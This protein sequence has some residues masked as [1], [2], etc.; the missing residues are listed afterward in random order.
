M[1]EEPKPRESRCFDALPRKSTV[2]LGLQ[3]GAL[4]AA[5]CFTSLQRSTVTAAATV[6][7]LRAAPWASCFCYCVSALLY[8]MLRK[9]VTSFY[10]HVR[11][12]EPE[13][14]VAGV[15]PPR[16]AGVGARI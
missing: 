11:N 2:L 6:H 15:T 13:T 4:G 8:K 14:P 1:A 5:P 9:G 7:F 12:E 10:S 3:C 16:S